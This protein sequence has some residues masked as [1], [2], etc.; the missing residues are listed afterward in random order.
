MTKIIA[1]C[2]YDW[3]NSSFSTIVTTFIIATYFTTALAS[4]PVQGTHQWGNA[5]ALAGLIIAICSPLMGAIADFQ[6]RRKPWLLLFT[7]LAILATGLIWFA[8]PSADSIPLTLT[9]VVLGTIGFEIATVFYNAMLPTL[10]PFH[11]IGRISGWA[12]GFGYAGGLLSLVIV[13]TFF[14][15]GKPGWLDTE[16]AEH[17]RISGPFVALWFG[18]FALPLFLL[19]P[20]T[21]QARFP[22]SQAVRVGVRNLI[23]TLKKLPQNRN[24]MLFLIAH[25]IFIDGLNT[26]FAFGGIFASGT[27]GMS[28]D[29]VITLG[30]ALN[31]SAGLGA[32][33]FA[34]LDDFLGSK[35]T[36]LT[37]LLCV[38]VL[39]TLVLFAESKSAFWILALLICLFFGPIQAASRSLMARISPER[40]HNEMFGLFALSG[41][42]TAFLGPWLFGLLTLKFQ[43]QRAGMASLIV[44]FLIGVVVLGFVNTKPKLTRN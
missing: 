19:V 11:Y 16:A 25:M 26:L 4:D 34:W 3:A 32:A 13:L 30:I 28:M 33:S 35:P 5:I 40:Q 14:V 43:S 31:V 9:F 36:I 15:Q 7:L 20:E 2:F 18:F 22:L 41:K 23:Q 44:L 17:I 12:W 24:V 29:E 6:G 27:F 39:G 8:E 37:A 42:I 1:W 38:I 10:V 21:V